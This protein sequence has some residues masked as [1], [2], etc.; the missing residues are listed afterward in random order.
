M[1]HGATRTSWDGTNFCEVLFPQNGSMLKN[2]IFKHFP[3]KTQ[4]EAKAG[5]QFPQEMLSISALT[6]GG[7][8]MSLYMEKT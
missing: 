5:R 7:G 6:L 1:K 8:V 2:Y 4:T 3:P